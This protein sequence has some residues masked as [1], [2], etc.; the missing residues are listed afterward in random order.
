[1]CVCVSYAIGLDLIGSAFFAGGILGIP[2]LILL[3]GICNE[4]ELCMFSVA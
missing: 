3:L 1:M 4:K 2:Y